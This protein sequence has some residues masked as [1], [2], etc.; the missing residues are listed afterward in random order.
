MAG[1]KVTVRQKMINM[2][3]LV[4][5]ALLALN[6]SA[7][8]LKSFHMVEVSMDSAGRNIDEK[9]DQTMKAIAK[10]HSDLPNDS[11]GT[12]AYEKSV[13]LKK[14]ADEGVK[15]VGELKD[16]LITAAGGRKATDE[17]PEGDP[18]EEIAQ[19]SNIELHANLMIN[20]GEG[21]KVKA[22][23]N[24]I[25]T[26]MLALLPAE[27]QKLIKSDLVA[28]DSKDGKQ[29]WESE[30]FEHTPLAAVVAL[31]SK[32]QND[33][34]NTESQILDV[35]KGSLTDDVQIV[36][37]FNAQII[38]TS[39]TYITLGNKYEAEI[40]LAA[41]SSRSEADIMVNGSKIQS[42]GGIGKYAVTATREGVNK[43]KAVISTVNSSG[44]KMTYEKEGEFFALAPIA[45]ISA[46]KMNVVY[47]GLDNP[48]SISVPGVGAN[49]VNATVSA[50][51]TLKKTKDG[52][53]MLQVTAA[54]RTVTVTAS[55]DGKVMGIK[56]YR[57]RQVPKP[58]PM[59]GS[60]EQSGSVSMGQ[61]KAANFV[62]TALKDFAFEGVNYTPTEYNLV[63]KPKNG[64]ATVEKGNSQNLTPRAK[65]LL[66]NARPGDIIIVMGIKARG[67][68]GVVPVPSSLALE[69]R[70]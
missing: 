1:G 46:T 13:Q 18:K 55:V 34:K 40:F 26:K 30:M 15:Y 4:L 67:P 70:Q 35:L 41:S 58:T 2:M 29:T 65:S 56:E 5:T 28:E 57:V 33:I 39:G 37:D 50:G 8:I 14:I 38:P 6:V 63:F 23:I 21:A 42:E 64:P 54:Q 20:Q 32:T 25:R 53:Y 31:L 60:I 7:E 61:L 22:K 10:F 19:A 24:E 17:F 9:N 59:L 49:K 45:V 62:L 51:G 69:V 16:Q 12:E 27:K 3:Y 47:I 48:I 52:E 43:F 36:T 66:M 44:K 68:A 11:K